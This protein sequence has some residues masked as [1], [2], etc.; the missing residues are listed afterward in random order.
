[1]RIATTRRTSAT[2]IDSSAERRVETDVRAAF[3]TIENPQ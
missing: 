2:H 3:V 1:M